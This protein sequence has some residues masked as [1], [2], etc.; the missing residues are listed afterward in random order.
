MADPFVPDPLTVAREHYGNDHWELQGF[1]GVLHEGQYKLYRN[2]SLREYWSIPA[3]AVRAQIPLENR[4]VV[5]F[6]AKGSA[7]LRTRVRS[8]PSVAD[9]PCDKNLRPRAHDYSPWRYQ[10]RHLQLPSCIRVQGNNQTPNPFLKRAIFVVHGIGDQEDSVTAANLRNALEDAV[11]ALDPQQWKEAGANRWIVPAPFVLDGFWAKYHDLSWIASEIF[12]DLSERPQRF[13]SLLWLGRAESAFQSAMWLARQAIG[14]PAK[15]TGPFSALYFLLLSGP[16]VLVSFG[17]L[18]RAGTRKILCK[19]VNDTLVYLEPKGDIQH[20]IVQRIDRRVGEQFL[21]LLGLD[22]DFCSIRP[23]GYRYVGA[24]PDAFDEVVWVAHS[25][26]SVIS[27][28]V[29]GDLLDQ[30][31]RIRTAYDGA[32]AQ[33]KVALS[34]RMNGVKKV[35]Q[36]LKHFITLGSPLDKIACLY[37]DPDT[38]RNT[39][40]RPWP[41]EYVDVHDARYIPD[42]PVFRRSL[43]TPKKYEQDDSSP[44]DPPQEQQ[45]WVNFHYASD[46]ISG[47]LEEFGD[48]VDNYHVKGL[49]VPGYSHAQYWKDPPI[50]GRILELT[51]NNYTKHQPIVQRLPFWQWCSLMSSFV[52]FLVLVSGLVAGVGWIL[53]TILSDWDKLAKLIEGWLI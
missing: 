17:M 7:V 42:S 51:F 9:L 39:V 37:R 43:L 30:C 25:L 33:G 19:Y 47:K 20:E 36:G 34:E 13:F 44:S 27:Y 10:F 29:I 4:Q 6:V 22:W 8:L 14:L 40:L 21:E 28:N 46:P 1:L 38:G 31:V 23:Q 5:L 16:L 26:G 50:V 15:A 49:K 32:D 53:W 48:L 52:L 3:Q 41:P 18:F 2:P 12:E 24:D 11:C 35:E 45:F